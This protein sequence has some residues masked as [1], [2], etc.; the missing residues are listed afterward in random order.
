MCTNLKGGRAKGTEP[1]AMSK[2]VLA[3][4]QEHGKRGEHYQVLVGKSCL[5]KIC[6]IFGADQREIL[7]FKFVTCYCHFRPLK[8]VL[9]P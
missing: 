1:A 6:R 5:N 9:P 8:F 4:Q 3:N 7:L 2:R